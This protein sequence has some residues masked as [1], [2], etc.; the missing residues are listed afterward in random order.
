MLVCGHGRRDVCCGSQGTALVTGCPRDPARFG[1]TV[2]LW[3]TSHTGGHRFA[4]TAIVLPQGTVWAYLDADAL[5]RITFRQGPLDDLLPRYRGCAGVGPAAV[6]ALEREAFAEVGWEW[7]DWQRR[8]SVGDD[9]GGVRLEAESPSR[10]ARHVDGASRRRADPPSPRMR[11][12]PRAGGE[13][14]DR[15]RRRG[16]HPRLVTAIGPGSEFEAAVIKLLRELRPGDVVTYG[17]LASEAGYPGLSRAVGTLLARSDDPT[18]PWWRVVNASGR[19]VPGH[20][21]EQARRLGAEG[22][23]ADVARRRVNRRLG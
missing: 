19:L 8:G 10:R 15:D 12:T 3:R 20:E 2:R 13:V 22:I 5:R 17:E 14:R 21:T 18:I 1:G 11:P 6:Q 9:G 23:V 7:L 4:P 16:R